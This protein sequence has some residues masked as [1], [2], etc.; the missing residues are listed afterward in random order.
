MAVGS[1]MMPIAPHAN[2]I[3]A[4][5]SWRRLLNGLEVHERRLVVQ[6]RLQQIHL[7]FE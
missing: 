1:W 7:R 5:P 2:G 6:C 3:V 4:G